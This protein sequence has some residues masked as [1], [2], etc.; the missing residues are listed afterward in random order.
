MAQTERDMNTLCVT[1]FI[2]PPGYITQADFDAAWA[3]FDPPNSFERREFFVRN[4]YLIPGE[5]E[6]SPDVFIDVYFF[7]S[8]WWPVLYQF[9]ATS[10]TTCAEPCALV[11]FPE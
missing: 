8:I 5:V 7:G 11:L 9:F 1:A 2:T 4:F 3:V 10:I 6:E